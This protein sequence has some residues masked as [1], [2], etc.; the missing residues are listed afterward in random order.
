MTPAA[1]RGEQKVRLGHQE[2]RVQ[3]AGPSLTFCVSVDKSL[4][5]SGPQFPHLSNGD[6]HLYS[7]TYRAL[8]E[9]QKG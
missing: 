3:A 1:A 9:G 7:S 2:P 8:R 5:L 6:A 4:P